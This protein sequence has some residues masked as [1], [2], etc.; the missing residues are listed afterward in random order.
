MEN[1][2]IIHKMPS[3]NEIRKATKENLSKLPDKYKKL[4]NPINY[5]VEMSG[6]LKKLILKLNKALKQNL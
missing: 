6:K 2:K 1:G 4:V 3:L 5:N